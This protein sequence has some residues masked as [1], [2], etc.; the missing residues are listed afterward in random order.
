MKQLNESR[1]I[2][3]LP[4]IYRTDDFLKRFLLIFES[5]WTPIEDMIG[6]LYYYF[7]P[8]LTPE[9]ML[10]YL[11]FWIDLKLKHNWP[12]EVKRRLLKNAMELYRW[13]GTKKGLTEYLRIFTGLGAEIEEEFPG[14]QLSNNTKLGVN[15]ILGG[16]NSYFFRVILRPQKGQRVEE[17]EIKEIIDTEKPAFAQYELVIEEAEED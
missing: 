3:F 14:M 9:E 4:G 10:D 8:M 15:T 6:Q 1:Y 16:K 2:N 13:R 5:V 7:D 11:S 12:T 17:K